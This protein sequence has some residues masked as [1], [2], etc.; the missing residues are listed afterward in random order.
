MV[1][2]EK[3]GVIHYDGD[4]IMTDKDICVEIVP[5]ALKC[6]CSDSEGWKDVAGNLQNM[7]VEHFNDMYMKSE[8]M[9]QKR[10]QQIQKFNRN[11]KKK[12][13]GKN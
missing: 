10:N 7:I 4:P 12:L 9:I 6:V 13:T 1:H 5:N 3:P 11:I 2:R 8:V